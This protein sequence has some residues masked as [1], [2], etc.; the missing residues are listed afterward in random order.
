VGYTREVDSIPN[1]IPASRRPVSRSAFLLQTSSS[2]DGSRE[3]RAGRTVE[4]TNH[5]PSAQLPP[6]AD[7]ETPLHPTACSG[8]AHS[9]VC[10]NSAAQFVQFWPLL[11][12]ANTT[13]V[14][15]LSANPPMTS[16]SI[17]HHSLRSLSAFAWA[18][19]W[20][21]NILLITLGSVSAGLISISITGDRAESDQIIVLWIWLTA[22]LAGTLVSVSQYCL[23][24][25]FVK[26]TSFWTVSTFVIVASLLGLGLARDHI[27]LVF[28]LLIGFVS[29]LLQ[30][31]Q[32]RGRVRHAYWWII[33]NTGTWAIVLWYGSQFAP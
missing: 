19:R 26:H 17:Q 16:P 31:F 30:W 6:R 33:I 9:H 8:T 18:W 28:G 4:M 15:I 20:L 11:L 14:D 32:L 3:Q 25:Q 7:P 1:V 2:L 21:A 24:L 10:Y 12:H 5:A 27:N 29:S 13:L 23:F 22:V